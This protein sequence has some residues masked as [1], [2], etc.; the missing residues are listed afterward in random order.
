MAYDRRRTAR[1]A[2]RTE[3]VGRVRGWR[4]PALATPLTLADELETARSLRGCSR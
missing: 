4:L 2:P 3:I 1:G